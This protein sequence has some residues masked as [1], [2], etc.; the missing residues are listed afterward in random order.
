MFHH[1]RRLCSPA[2]FLLSAAALVAPA[3]AQQQAAHEAQLQILDGSMNPVAQDLVIL[4]DGSGLILNPTVEENGI[5]KLVGVGR[6]LSIEFTSKGPKARTLELTLDPAPKVF[7]SMIVDPATGRVKELT[8]KSAVHAFRPKQRRTDRGGTTGLHGVPANDLCAAP[9]SITVG[10]TAIDNTLAGTDGPANACATMGADLWYDY[11]ATGNGTLTVSTCNTIDFDSIIAIHSGLTC[12]PAAPIACNDDNA[13]AGCTGNTSEVSTAVTSGTH[14]LIRVGGWNGDTG[15]GTLNLSFSGGGGGLANDDCATPTAVACGSSTTVN[16]ATATTAVNDPLL[17]CFFGGPA[18]GLGSVWFSFVAPGT[19]VTLDTSASAVS[20]TVMGLFEGTCGSLTELACDDDGGTGLRSLISYNFLTPG[21]TYLVEVTSFSAASLGSITLDITCNVGPTPGDACADAI[22]IACG[23]SATVNNVSFG[24]DVDDPEFSCAFFGP[25][26][27]VGTAWFKFMATDTSALI[28][29]NASTAFDTL[30]AVYEGGCGAFTELACSDDEGV[31][32]LSEICITGL[33]PGNTYYIQAA[34]F[35]A[36]DTGDVTVTVTCPCPAPPA[37]DDCINAEALVLPTSVVV[38]VTNAT[39]DITVACDVPNNGPLHNVWY[40]VAGTGT[41]LTAS[42]CNGGTA[43][44]DTTISVFCADCGDRICVAGND[45]DCD[46]GGPTFASTVSWCSQVGANYFVTV[47]TW[48]AGTTPGVIQLD[49]FDTGSSCVA[50]VV[51]LPQGACCLPG[52]ACAVTTSD[53]CAAQGGT[54]QGDGTVCNANFVTDGS[55]EGGPFGGDWSEFSTNFGTPICDSGSCGFGGGTGPRTGD[56]WVWFGG[57]GA[58]EQGSMEQAVTIPVGASTL[59]FWLEIPVS[60]GNGVD[61]VR[62]LIDGSPVFTAL[63]NDGVYAGIGYKLVSVALGG[64]ADG[65]VHTLRFE[66]TQTGAGGAITNFFID[67]V[68]INVQTVSCETCYTLD[69]STDDEGNA[70]PHGAKVDTEFD[71][72]SNYPVTITGSANPSNA[73]TAAI[74]NST[75]GPASQDPDLLVGSGNILILQTDSNQSQ[76]GAGIY[77]SH[78]DDEDGGTLSF[79]F[80]T[81]TTPMSIVL[82]DIDAADPASSVVLTD[83]SGNTRTYAVPANWTGDLVTDGPPGKGTLD[84]TTLA[85]QP[86]FGSVATA[87]EDVGFNP[88]DVV[89]IDVNLGGS[90]GV[91]DLSWCQ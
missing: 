22:E 75:T 23:G 89:R 12:P 29:T 90:G 1:V 85:N 39:D 91:D 19:Q 34:S 83:G 7:V 74:L 14:Y 16:N 33:T 68:S 59:D 36:L 8:Q 31:G 50:D 87:S 25:Q 82:I 4:R 70:M 24:T 17:S 65:G 2:L 61:F 71:G 88:D 72:G 67:D 41:T 62:A 80:N 69:F 35:S 5:L 54:Y 21:N 58:F 13:G 86:G 46:A 78:N 57:I 79:A 30:L 51:C 49:V 37:N 10:A 84:L 73:N 32:L 9:Q 56:F 44:T 45:D 20:D 43:V 18:Q 60:S 81:G 55:F 66:S 38:D 40:S 53:D 63:E 11:L 76:C 26:Q 52:G 42:T 28:D 3:A 77:C 15:S 27:G 6:K 47:G 48:S 64:A